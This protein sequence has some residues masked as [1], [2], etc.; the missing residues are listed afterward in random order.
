MELGQIRMFKAVVDSGSVVRAAE[1]CCCVPSNVT[2]RIKALEQE[3]GTP[4]FRREGRGLCINP[5]GQVFLAYAEKIL[6]LVVEAKRAVDPASSPCGTLRIGSIESSATGRLP[7]LLA[8]YHAQFPQVDLQLSTGTWPHLLE[9]TLNHRL[10]GAVV[11]VPVMRP[12]LDKAVIYTED[13]VLI[14]S[15]SM[16]PLRKPADIAG[17]TLFM[18]PDGCPYRAALE[19]WLHAHRLDLPIVSYASYGAIVG[20]VSAGAGISLVPKGIFLQ[21]S[22]ATNLAGYEF[23][24]LNAIDNLFIWHKDTKHHPARDAFI[25]MLQEDLVLG[26]D[27]ALLPPHVTLCRVDVA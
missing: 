27:T 13:L 24:D 15:K 22:Q 12:G 21:Y 6:A 25:A 17:K 3:L 20:C 23:S 1:M 7:R 10:D 16:G 19:R 2:A 8:K 26:L 14:A 11:A 9:D 18:W 5:A 4:L